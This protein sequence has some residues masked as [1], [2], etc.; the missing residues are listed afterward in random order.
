MKR[1]LPG[2][3]RDIPGVGESIARA[4]NALGVERVEQLRGQRPETLYERMME[5]RGRHVDRCMLYVLRCAVYFA[6]GGRD[7]A[8][9]RWWNWKDRRKA[10]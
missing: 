7:P 3:L 6:E 2:D 4:L 1:T 9:L 8:R 10:G 5:R